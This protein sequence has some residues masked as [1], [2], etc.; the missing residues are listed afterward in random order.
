VFAVIDVETTGGQLYEDRITEIAIYK[1][2]GNQIIDSYSTL[3]NPGRKIMPFVVKLTGITD[4]M[5]SGA[6]SF[7]EVAD[8]IDE[9]TRDTVFVAHNIA[10]DY[11][12]VKR[13]FKRIGKSFKRNTLCT[14]KLSQKTLK[15]QPSYS[16]GNLC[17]N[18][19][20][21]I[22]SRHIAAGDAEATVLLFH[23][24]IE[25]V[26]LENLRKN[27]TDFGQLA[28]LKG[29]ITQEMIDTLPEDPGIFRFLDEQGKVL[30]LKSAKNI[31]TEASGFLINEAKNPHFDG[32]FEKIHKID[33]TV[34]NS[35]LISQ[36]QEIEEIRKLKPRFCK[37]AY[38][39]PYPIGIYENSE[40]DK[41]SLY[42]ERSPNGRALWRF[43]TE[44]G[45]HKF[46]KSFIK[47]FQL[48]NHNPAD[49]S[50]P[51]ALRNHNIRLNEALAQKLYPYRN[52]FLVREV[53]FANVVYLVYVED[54]VYQ[55]FAEIDMDIYDAS[56]EAMKDSIV[57]CDN[58][59]FVQR[60]LQN[61][62]RKKRH[63][64]LIPC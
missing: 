27:E 8:I 22:N 47:H 12:V 14:V 34:I 26:G 38:T 13:E 61:Y 11:S 16:L 48:Q 23:K 18:L 63:V 56:T 50:N 51:E 60:I 58:N 54:F 46:L 30:Y 25:D 4:D 52:F 43:Q 21:Q 28:E 39:R 7:A 59:P 64:K 53:P 37:S 31:Y 49:K 6:P 20:I 15:N 9:F 44:K 10:F 24:I 41:K 29:A 1:T 40:L 55:G 2:D 33:S 17:E 3:V 32:L 45:A 35:F 57:I 5:V 62:I 42:V 19:G 36:L